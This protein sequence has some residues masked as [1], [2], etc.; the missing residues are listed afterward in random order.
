MMERRELKMGGTQGVQLRVSGGREGI[1]ECV[2][3]KSIIVQKQLR[4]Q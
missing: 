3:R 4:S 1:E 2:R